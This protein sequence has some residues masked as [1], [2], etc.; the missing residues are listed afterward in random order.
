MHLHAFAV[1]FYRRN[2]SEL[3]V[4]C[5][6]LHGLPVG[7]LVESVRDTLYHSL[8]QA[9]GCH[10]AID[11]HFHAHIAQGDFRPERPCGDFLATVVSVRHILRRGGNSATGYKAHRVV[12]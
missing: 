5:G 7:E 11:A 6:Q 12:S 8:F 10:R 4:A 1:N 2:I 3:G 9:R